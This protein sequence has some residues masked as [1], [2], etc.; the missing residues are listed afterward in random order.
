MK[1]WR[2]NCW[3][4]W[5]TYPNP[6]ITCLLEWGARSAVDWS[7]SGATEGKVPAYS[8][9]VHKHFPPPHQSHSCSLEYCMKLFVQHLCNFFRFLCNL[10]YL[11]KTVV[12]VTQITCTNGWFLPPMF[13]SDHTVV[14]HVLTHLYMLPTGNHSSWCILSVQWQ[15]FWPMW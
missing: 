9:H 15:A 7:C 4:S 6:S 5:V 11:C 1:L 10:I 12:L 3:S 2:P 8:H 14:Y 13:L